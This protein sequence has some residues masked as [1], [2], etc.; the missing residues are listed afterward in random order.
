MEEEKE[1][2]FNLIR[3]KRILSSFPFLFPRRKKKPGE[4]TFLSY[5]R[6]K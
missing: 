6:R 3:N 2:N 4:E 1:E 5:V